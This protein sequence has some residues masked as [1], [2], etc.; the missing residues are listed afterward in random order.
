M[1]YARIVIFVLLISLLFTGC[2]SVPEPYTYQGGGKTIEVYPAEG[3]LVCGLEV[4]T[5]T[6][7][8]SGNSTHYHITYPN[9]GSYYW[10]QS[11][12]SGSGGG[13]DGYNELMYI[14]GMTLV[15]AIRAGEDQTPFPWYALILGGLG[16]LLFFFPKESFHVTYGW[17]FR[18]AE[19]SGAYLG[20]TRFTGGAAMAL[21]VVLFLVWMLS[22]VT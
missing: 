11:G 7:S 15:D 9:G 10:S 8:E 5:Y 14:P 2:T 1:K 21:A 13:S 19:P 12:W 4:Y 22:F 20:F 16:A 17:R 3:K 18:D 6:V